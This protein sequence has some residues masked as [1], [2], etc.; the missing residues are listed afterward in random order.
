MIIGLVGKPSSGKSTFFKAAT[1]ANVEISP[2]PFTTIKPNRGTAYVS[3]GCVDKEFN[4]QCQPRFGYCLQHKRFIPVDVLDVAGLIPGS[5]RGLGLGNQFLDDLRQAD[6]LIHVVDISGT[7]NEQ[8]QPTENHDP[9]KDIAFL[10]EELDQWYLSILKKGWD[11]F[12]RT[13]QQEHQ[14][15]VRAL[16]KQLSGLKV[17][18]QMVEQSIKKLKLPDNPVSWNGQ[19]LFSLT[20]ELRK[21]SKPMI[22]SANKIDMPNSEKNFQLIK[23]QFPN[24]L[25]LP[26]SAESELALR[27]ASKHKLI[28]YIPGEKDFQ[29]LDEEKL[30]QQQAEALK[31]IE[32]NVLSKHHAT[33]IQECLDR[34]VFDFLQ[35][36]A[37]FPGGVN[38]LADREG[39]V[40]PDCFLLP[41]NSTALDFA[42][43]IHADIGKNFIKAIDVKNKKAVG[44]EHILHHRDVIEIMVKK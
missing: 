24:Y 1:L 3:L 44:K 31:F 21:Q 41:K 18:E 33:G 19:Q 2:R 9:A 29:I 39:R 26:C 25:I 40:L 34:A 30:S 16:A 17:N 12:S 42:F 11:K 13:V 23:K 6:I 38:K 22:I 32:K 8:G 43:K 35:Y 7:T 27:E 15:I 37:I 14:N 36:I 5:H 10:E 20:Q 4:V 28:R